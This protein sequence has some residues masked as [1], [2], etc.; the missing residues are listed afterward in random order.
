MTGEQLSPIEKAKSNIELAL[1]KNSELYHQL[2]DSDKALTLADLNATERGAT[3]IRSD[4][5]RELVTL[6][7]W[8]DSSD[9]NT[10][11]W[12]LAFHDYPDAD[13]AFADALF[14]KTNPLNNTLA[15]MTVPKQS[16]Q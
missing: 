10:M 9:R 6:I 16:L 11:T 3:L 1:R 8:P 14:A 12:D 2:A 7:D 4:E 15:Y 5:F 13:E